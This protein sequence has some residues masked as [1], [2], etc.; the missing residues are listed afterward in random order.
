MNHIMIDLETMGNKAGC[1]IMAIAAVQ[2]DLETGKTGE[3]FYNR[4]D[5]QSCLDAGLTVQAST[6]EWWMLQNENARRKLIEGVSVTLL[7][8]LHNLR[9]WINMNALEDAQVWGNSARFD[10]GI[11]EAAYQTVPGVPLPWKFYNERDVRTLVSFVPEIKANEPFLGDKHDPIHD[12]LHQIKYCHKTWNTL[13]QP[14]L[15]P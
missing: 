9:M 11:L 4:I 2:F 12:C 14:Q 3:Q 10:L 15:Q 13:T 8:G 5:L 6:V 7:K 1:A